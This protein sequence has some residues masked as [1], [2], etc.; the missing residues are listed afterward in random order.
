MP[1]LGGSQRG[2]K[3]T[4]SHFTVCNFHYPNKVKDERTS[5]CKC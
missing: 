5:L 4:F 2:V 3:N 1:K